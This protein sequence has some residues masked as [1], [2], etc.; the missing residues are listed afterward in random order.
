MSPEEEAN[1]LARQAAVAAAYLEDVMTNSTN[2][3]LRMEAAKII[4]ETWLK[5]NGR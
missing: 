2:L 3:N 4:L 5:A 1:E